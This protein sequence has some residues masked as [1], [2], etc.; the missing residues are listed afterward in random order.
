MLCDRLVCGCKDQH[1]QCK[2]LAK[3]DLKFEKAFK[4]AKEM[5]AAKKKQRTCRTH[6]I[7]Q[8][9]DLVEGYPVDKLPIKTS[10]AH[11]TRYREHLLHLIFT[12][13]EQST[14]LQIVNFKMLSVT[15]AKRR[16]ISYSLKFLRAK[17]FKVE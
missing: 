4:I 15:S 16:V 6:P 8:L 9:I 3:S 5:E 17:I 7:L 12:D 13:V 1:L 11:Q 14:K 2:L 10:I